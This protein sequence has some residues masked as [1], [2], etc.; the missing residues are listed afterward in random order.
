VREKAETERNMRYAIAIVLVAAA[1]VA[2][3][4]RGSLHL[5][6]HVLFEKFNSGGL[7]GHIRGPRVHSEYER[8]G[9]QI[10][11]AIVI[12]VLGIGAA[13][14]VVARGRRS[15]VEIALS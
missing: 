3:V 9:W 13:V 7:G 14:A 8:A 4:V 5:G 10:P 6:P 11:V 2:A 15:R 12:G 1:V